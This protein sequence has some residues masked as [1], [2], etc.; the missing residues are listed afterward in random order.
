MAHILVMECL[1]VAHRVT[2]VRRG[3]LLLSAHSGSRGS[4]RENFRELITYATSR[5]VVSSALVFSTRSFSPA[6]Q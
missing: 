4:A 6:K 1:L 3:I 5:S 2:S